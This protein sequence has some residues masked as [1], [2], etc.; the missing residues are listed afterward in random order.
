MGMED[1]EGL[2]EQ[3]LCYN[4]AIGP[5]QCLSMPWWVRTSKHKTY[6]PRHHCQIEPLICGEDAFKRIQGDILEARRTVEIITWGFDPGMVLVR[7]RGGE[8]GMR[9][10]DLL[11]EIAT[12]KDNP[13]TVRLLLWH[14]NAASYSIQKNNPG[15]YGTR[16]PTIGG[17]AGYYSETHDRYNREWFEEVIAN[18]V[19][20]I[21]L[22]TR[23]IA[24]ACRNA[25]LEGENYKLSTITGTA[26]RSSPPIIRR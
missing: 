25:A 6:A 17:S 5:Y 16:I 12:R 13:V 26:S 1:N 24:L 14:D 19:P 2:Y 9:Y 3:K 11:K 15:L 23:E 21:V 18:K 7:D 4:Q 20:N 22:H 10:G 8:D